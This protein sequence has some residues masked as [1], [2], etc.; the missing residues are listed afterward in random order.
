[1]ETNLNGYNYH[2]FNLKFIFLSLKILI[3]LCK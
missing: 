3:G 1:M 2:I